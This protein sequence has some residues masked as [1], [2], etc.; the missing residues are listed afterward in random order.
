MPLT[1]VLDT[2]L[3]SIGNFLGDRND[4]GSNEVTLD[5]LLYNFRMGTGYQQE[6]L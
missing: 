1:P 5:G 2:E 6:R 3:L 4:F